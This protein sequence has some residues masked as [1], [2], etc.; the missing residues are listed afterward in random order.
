MSGI[1]IKTGICLKQL[2][3]VKILK[4]TNFLDEN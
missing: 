4:V 3:A 1:L 2:M